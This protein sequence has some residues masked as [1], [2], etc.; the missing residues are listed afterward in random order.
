MRAFASKQGS[1]RGKQNYRLPLDHENKVCRMRAF[2]S[3]RSERV[4]AKY[5]NIV[6]KE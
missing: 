2:A 4:D 3:K 6:K 1:K 5:C